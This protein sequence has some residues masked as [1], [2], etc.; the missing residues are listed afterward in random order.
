MLTAGHEVN[1]ISLSF[2]LKKQ[3]MGLHWGTCMRACNAVQW[4]ALLLSSIQHS[5]DGGMQCGVLYVKI[6]FTDELAKA[7]PDASSLN[8]V[9]NIQPTQQG[10]GMDPLA[11]L[12]RPTKD[13]SPVTGGIA[14]G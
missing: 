4:H 12:S 11:Q 8:L 10:I 6:D 3:S 13:F 1:Q 7:R 2:N 9:R 5:V 14:L